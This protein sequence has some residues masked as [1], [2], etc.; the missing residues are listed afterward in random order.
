MDERLYWHW[1]C[2]ME[3][4]SPVKKT[5]L[6]R[7]YPSPEQLYNIEEKQL[8]TLDFLTDREKKQFLNSRNE[9]KEFR[10]TYEQT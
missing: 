10:K 1:L 5:R 6:L 4:L 2:S 8:S 9:E 3:G 7:L